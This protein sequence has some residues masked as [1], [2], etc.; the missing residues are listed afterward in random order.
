MAILKREACWNEVLNCVNSA[1][2]LENMEP[3]TP[4]LSGYYN[5][6]SCG[7]ANLKA[8]AIAQQI[9]GKCDT[10]NSNNPINSSNTLTYNKI[11]VAASSSLLSW[12]A[13]NTGTQTKNDSC[14]TYP[15]P[16]NFELTNGTCQQVI[17]DQ[18]GDC[19]TAANYNQIIHVTS[20][21]TNYC[22][23]GK[24][25]MFGNCCADEYTNNGI[26]VPSSSD[27]TNN[28]YKALLL[29]NETCNGTEDYYC[30]ISSRQISVYCITTADHIDYDDSSDGFYIE[31][32]CPS[33]GA[34]PGRWIL[35]DQYGNYFNV[36]NQSG[37]PT[38]TYKESC[39][40]TTNQCQTRTY[41]YDNNNNTWSFGGTAVTNAV[42]TD[43]EFIIKYQ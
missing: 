30:P 38:M 39:D 32:T 25:D 26:C 13:T 37:A 41:Q 19:E 36:Q 20:D 6:D 2:N 3:G 15:C 35:V 43:N 11:D 5:N 18:T 1:D 4:L 29:V 16:M 22:A 42:P 27:N 40:C 7:S 14:N 34:N 31:Y 23:S 9:W 8:C 12:L 10:D 24:R 28:P 17:A 21:L 33:D